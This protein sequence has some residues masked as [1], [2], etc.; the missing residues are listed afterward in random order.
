M[1]NGSGLFTNKGPVQGRL[2]RPGGVRGE[3]LDLRNDV[4]S[5]LAPLVTLTI[6]EYTDPLAP[7][8]GA[9]E[10][11]TASQVTARTA[12]LLQ[13]GLDELDIV[14]R[15][16]QFTTAGVTPADA[17]ATATI[18]GLDANSEETTETVSLAQTATTATSETCFKGTDL[19]IVYAVG[20]GAGAT[21]AIGYPGVLAL[22]KPIKSRAGLVTAVQEI[23]A[24][25]VVDTGTF[26]SPTTNPPNGAYEP[27]TP[28]DGSND[29][30]V[31]YE[32]DPTA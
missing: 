29:Y 12:V 13:A 10:A 18:T 30:A 17:P 3:V 19:E 11:A 14:A 16:I 15:P 27:A 21:I 20:D 23:E 2:L 4:V 28:P 32:F 6:D 26:T 22:N 1:S 25:S 5:A 9:L 31:Y 7:A 24:G 8:A